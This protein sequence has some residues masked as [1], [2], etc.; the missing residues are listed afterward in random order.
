MQPDG[1]SRLSLRKELVSLPQLPEKL[2]RPGVYEGRVGFPVR[3][4]FRVDDGGLQAI[5]K[6]L[7]R[8]HQPRWAGPNNQDIGMFCILHG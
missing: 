3:S 7:G 6:Q 5:A 1:I 4:R 8:H 2:Q